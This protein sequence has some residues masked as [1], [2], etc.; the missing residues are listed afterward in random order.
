MPRG[1]SR[2]TSARR[3]TAI[4]RSTQTAL[5]SGA[6]FGFAGQVDGIVERMRAELGGEARDGRDRA[7]SPG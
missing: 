3:A 2:S 6:V 7:G 4:G 1:S 5:Q